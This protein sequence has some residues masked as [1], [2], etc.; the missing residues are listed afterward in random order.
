[1]NAS[2]SRAMELRQGIDDARRGSE[3]LGQKL[4]LVRRELARRMAERDLQQKA[5]A[6]ALAFARAELREAELELGRDAIAAAA[7]AQPGLP[8]VTSRQAR[9]VGVL[10]RRLT[11]PAQPF[12]PCYGPGGTAASLDR[13]GAAYALLLP[14]LVGLAEA[15]ALVRLLRVSL[16]KTAR[17]LNALEKA[18]LPRLLGE[19]RATLSALEEDARDEAVRARRLFSGE[20]MGGGIAPI[21]GAP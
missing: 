1:M 10:W 12:R 14:L 6:T 4:E 3:V 8:A 9:S 2:R 5:V 18:I 15:E 16:L 20:R 7:L 13:A 17:R 19:L 21:D 11:L